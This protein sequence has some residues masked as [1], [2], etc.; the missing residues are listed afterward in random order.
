MRT[1]LRLGTDKAADNGKKQRECILEK[2]GFRAFCQKAY[3]KLGKS[4]KA[5]EGGGCGG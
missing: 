3:R 4:D 2:F 1:R 5:H